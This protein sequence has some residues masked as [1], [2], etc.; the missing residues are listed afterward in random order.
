M[1]SG[2]RE[3]RLEWMSGEEGR[4][5]ESGCGRLGESVLDEGCVPGPMTLASLSS[6]SWENL[7]STASIIAAKSWN[8]VS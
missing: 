6:S 1:G 3:G 8:G 4:R 2:G 5:L 7:M